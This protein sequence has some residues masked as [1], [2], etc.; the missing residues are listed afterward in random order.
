MLKKTALAIAATAMLV[1]TGV[2]V[3][4]KT[5]KVQASSKG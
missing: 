2:A 5:L 3:E 4:A 1:T